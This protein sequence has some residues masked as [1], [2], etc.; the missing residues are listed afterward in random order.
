MA[1]VSIPMGKSLDESKAFR[2]EERSIAELFGDLANETS[3]LIKQEVKLASTEVAQKAATAGK[4]VGLV[5]AGA[6]LG[7]MGL[8]LLLQALVLGLS[9]GMELWLASLL[10]GIVVAAVAA[11]LTVKAITA[12][13]AMDLVPRESVQSLAND[14]NL[15]QDQMR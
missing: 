14:R 7:S 3:T 2:P 15:L 12:L 13:R 8:L 10:V 4:Q 6:L 5:G 9:T 1:A 11:L